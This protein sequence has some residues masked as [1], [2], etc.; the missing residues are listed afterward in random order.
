MGDITTRRRYPCWNPPCRRTVVELA[1]NGV[2]FVG[3]P[4][5]LEFYFFVEPWRAFNMMEPELYTLTI[6]LFAMAI[7]N[8]LVTWRFRFG[9]YERYLKQ[10]Y[11]VKNRFIYPIMF[12]RELR[13]TRLRDSHIEV[14]KI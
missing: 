3:R 10:K 13:A 7:I 4:T 9:V 6:V 5:P 1:L 14:T 2:D 8:G 11:R 12:R